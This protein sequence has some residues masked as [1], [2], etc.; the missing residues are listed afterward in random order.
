MTLY[1]VILLF[2]LFGAGVP[3]AIALVMCLIGYFLSDP[4]I[5]ATVIIQRLVANVENPS[6]MA[7]PMF[8]IA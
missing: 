8:I 1:P 3:V 6:M 4:Y 5:S 7:A 2:L